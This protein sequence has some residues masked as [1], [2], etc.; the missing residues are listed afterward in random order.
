[1][2]YFDYYLKPDNAPIDISF[3]FEDERPAGKHGFMKVIGDHFEF[4]DGAPARFWGVNF[5]G[6]ACFPEHDYAPVLAKRLAKFGI[7][8]VRF[9][10]LEAEWNTPNIFRYTKGKILDSTR[11]LDSSSMERLD[12]LIYCLKQ[13]GIYVYMD[14]LTYRKFKEGDGVA[15]AAQL[16]DGAKPYCIFNRQLIELQKEFAKQVFEHVNPYTGLAYK[17]EPAI[18]LTEIVNEGDLFSSQV[19]V[20]PYITEFRARFREWLDDNKIE[21]DAENCEPKCMYEPLVKFKIHL[22]DQYYEEMRSCLREIGVRIPITGTNWTQN[23]ANLVSNIKLDFTDSHTYYYDWNWQADRK[24]CMQQSMTEADDFGLVRLIHMCTLDKP[25]FVSE[26]DMPWPNDYRAE[27]PIVM[28][29]TGALQG[30][31]GFVIHAYSYLPKQ[32]DI[33]LLGKELCADAIGGVCY[34]QGVFST[35]NDPAKT[36]LFYHSALITRR[37]DVEKAKRKVAVKVD[38][39]H[40]KERTPITKGMTKEATFNAGFYDEMAPAY[41]CLAELSKVGTCFDEREDVD[42]LLTEPKSI[43]A[44]DTKEVLSDTGELYRSW[45]KNYGWV[46]TAMTKSIYGFLKKNGIIEINGLSVECHTDFAV[47]A[48]SSLSEQSISQSNNI[49]LTTIGRARNAGVKYDG[50]EMV[51]LGNGPVQVENIYAK[52]KLTT[53]QKNMTVWSV[54]PEGCYQGKIPCEWEDGVLTFTVGEQWNSMYYLLQT[55]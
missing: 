14:L 7:N 27:S 46:D 35:W 2:E 41:K 8:M 10:Q 42:V 11:S 43:L 38:P 26:W 3:V 6:G 40:P 21:F 19:K 50:L 36:G 25:F 18:V 54:T 16:N 33:P 9:H 51:E 1:M 31:G 22:Q 17:D 45:E 30:W 4:E 52:I 37:G 5:N 39:Y 28:A 20:E 23:S 24:A 12:Y 48:M 29:A 49:L 55:E 32:G 53:S 15:S 44:D 34:R 13:E 47:I